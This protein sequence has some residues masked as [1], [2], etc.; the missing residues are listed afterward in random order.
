MAA[1]LVNRIISRLGAQPVRS[2][3]GMAVEGRQL[4]FVPARREEPIDWS[5]KL[6]LTLSED[7]LKGPP[8]LLGREI[9]EGLDRQEI[10]ET[11]CLVCLPP[12]RFMTLPIPTPELA[13]DDLDSFLTLQAENAFP[14]S[15]EELRLAWHN[16]KAPD[17]ERFT[18]LAATARESLN[19]IEALLQHA[20]LRPAG[21][22]LGLAPDATPDAAR[23]ELIL[24]VR[25][26][27][28][29]CR[30]GFAI[31]RS[32]ETVFP[33]DGAA[34]EPVCQSLGR[35]LRITLG[36]LSGA[37]R[38]SLTAATVYHRNELPE[39][40]SRALSRELGALDLKTTFLTGEHPALA[41]ALNERLEGRATTLDFLPPKRSV[42]EK[43]VEKTASRRNV[44]IGGGGGSVLLLS[45]C[46]FLFQGWQL[47]SLE[48]RW[49]GMAEKVQTLETLQQ[50]IRRFEPWYDDSPRSLLILRQLATL[51]PKEGDIWLSSLIIKDNRQVICTGSARSNDDILALT[52]RLREAENVSEVALPST[53]GETFRLNFVWQPSKS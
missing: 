21:L 3:L 46:L 25:P 6:R 47:N 30:V 53:S 34:P 49:E 23:P 7:P 29:V 36:Q 13:D 40:W 14:F 9:R 51:F 28:I 42:W 2:L 8:E 4:T 17:G 18:L 35:E 16:W 32:L 10:R 12:E 44:W 26:D 15:G 37:W 11:N 48:N 22:A 52:E 45:L 50:Q 33:G 20:G 39:A 19:Q 31:V 27:R 1:G 38:E 5:A 24:D 41:A 43:L